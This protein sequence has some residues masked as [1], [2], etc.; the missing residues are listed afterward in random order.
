MPARQFRVQIVLPRGLSYEELG[1]ESLKGWDHER[2]DRAR[3]YGAK[4]FEERRSAILIVPSVPAWPDRNVLINPSHP[5]ASLI[6]TGREVLVR[7]DE[8]LFA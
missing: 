3:A 1:P 5:E 2:P 8:R 4:W 7:W 6:E